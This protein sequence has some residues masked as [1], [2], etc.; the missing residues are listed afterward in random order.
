MQKRAANWVLFRRNLLRPVATA[1]CTTHPETGLDL[2]HP[3]LLSS[4]TLN[5][6]PGAVGLPSRPG[7]DGK[8]PGHPATSQIYGVPRPKF[9]K[10]LFK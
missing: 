10:N 6:L 1:L 9:F 5:L 2:E 8:I 3:W 4:L 7:F